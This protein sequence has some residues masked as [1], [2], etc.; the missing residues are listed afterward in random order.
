MLDQL[1]DGLDFPAPSPW[2]RAVVFTGAFA[3]AAIGSLAYVYTQ[4]PQ[5]RAVS[6]LHI[7]AAQGVAEPETARTPTLKQMP[8][9]FLTEIQV[10][11]SRPLIED[12][13]DRLRKVGPVPD[14]GPD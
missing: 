6:R 3:F 9:S 13:L 2:R 8:Q 12:T 4:T 11:T 10:L 1:T 7:T 5:Y 14:L